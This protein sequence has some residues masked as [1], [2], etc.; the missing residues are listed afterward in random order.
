VSVLG[1]GALGAPD[2]AVHVPLSRRHAMVGTL[3]G[4][5][6]TVVADPKLVATLNGETMRRAHLLYAP[7]T[8]FIFMDA[9][10]GIVRGL[11]L[12]LGEAVSQPVS[13][14]GDAQGNVV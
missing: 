9:R 1:H 12:L 6:G 8:E 13:A 7:T 5:A 14:V 11:A 4:S 2:V 3:V 10:R